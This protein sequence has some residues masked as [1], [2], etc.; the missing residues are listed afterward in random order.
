VS[1][2]PDPTLTPSNSQVICTL[3]AFEIAS[4]SMSDTGLLPVSSFAIAERSTAMPIN[5]N[6]AARSACVILKSFLAFRTLGPTMFFVRT[7]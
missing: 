3:R 4:T 5:C 6:R 2:V 7:S 1:G